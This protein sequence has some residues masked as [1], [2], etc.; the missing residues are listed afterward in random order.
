MDILD[1]SDALLDLHAY[2]DETGEPFVICSKKDLAGRRDQAVAHYRKAS[3]GGKIWDLNRQAKERRNRP[4]TEKDLAAR[5]VLHSPLEDWKQ[6][7]D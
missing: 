4:F 3:E 7:I 5:P 6:E 2:N 1:R